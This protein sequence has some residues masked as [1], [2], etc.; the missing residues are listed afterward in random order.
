M[1]SFLRSCHNYRGRYFNSLVYYIVYLLLKS[2]VSCF[3]V[4]Q[5][6]CTC[7]ATSEPLAFVQFVHYI[8]SSALVWVIPLVRVWLHTFRSPGS[9]KLLYSPDTDVYHIGLPLLQKFWC[10]RSAQYHIFTWEE[11]VISHAIL[12]AILSQLILT[13]LLYHLRLV[14]N[15]YK[16]FLYVQGVTTS[17]FLLDLERLLPYVLHSSIQTLSMPTSNACA[18]I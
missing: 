15:I 18:Y 12:Y 8:S 10:L 17:P 6:E 16:L 14:L 2:L 7:R 1:T 9:K 3:S 13:L 4:W 11:I 5:T